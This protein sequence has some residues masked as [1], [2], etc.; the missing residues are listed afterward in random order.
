MDFI[1]SDGIEVTKTTLH[2]GMKYLFELNER[3]TRPFETELKRP[4]QKA[5]PDLHGLNLV[6]RVSGLAILVKDKNKILLKLDPEV[7][8]SW[9]KLNAEER[10]FSLLFFWISLGEE[11]ILGERSG[12]FESS[13]LNALHIY[14][15]ASQGG[16]VSLV[17]ESHY[18]G[19]HN[20]ALLAL[21]GFI[22]AGSKKSHKNIDPADMQVGFSAF[23]KAM[24]TYLGDAV[25]RFINETGNYLSDELYDFC[26]KELKP[27]VPD[28]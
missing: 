4:Q 27:L 5:F 1:G 24:L 15:T 8:A 9:Q 2:I 21:F 10:Y 13:F 23:G 12:I 19:P 25:T 7:L 20:I 14:R 28:W 11:E 17:I 3:M 18:Y 22:K 6:L 26:A 16:R